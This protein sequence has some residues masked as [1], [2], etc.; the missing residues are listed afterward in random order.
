MP[1]PRICFQSAALTAVLIIGA[2]SANGQIQ[3]GTTEPAPADLAQRVAAAE[4]QFPSVLAKA[5]TPE[6][7]AA[8]LLII[9]N[10]PKQT[11]AGVTN[12]DNVAAPCD[13][14]DTTPLLGPEQF[15][16]FL[17]PPPNGG[18][19]LNECAMFGIDAHS[20]PNFLAFNN[21]ATYTSGGIPATPELIVLDRPSTSSVSFWVSCG[22]NV[23]TPVWCSGLRIQ[24]SLGSFD[25]SAERQVETGD[26]HCTG[27]YRVFPGGQSV[28]SAG[29]RRPF[30]IATKH[31][32]AG[33][34]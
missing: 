20:P 16:F 23:S 14:S 10:H 27:N 25:R 15:A 1:N 3:N 12:F 22:S 30:A 13:F 21:T 9:K 11:G 19:I 4:A 7:V 17:A 29:G 24:W 5:L 8:V 33:W 6:S 2:F 26:G 34:V 28:C 18:A 31:A 32:R